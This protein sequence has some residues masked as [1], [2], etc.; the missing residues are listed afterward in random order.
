MLNMAEHSTSGSCGKMSLVSNGGSGRSRMSGTTN[1]LYYAV[2]SSLKQ[3]TS[4]QAKEF[5]KGRE[6]LALHKPCINLGLGIGKE[7]TN[8]QDQ[9]KKLCK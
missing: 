3:V 6:R 1:I 7:S 2:C 8:A 9:A 5:W 4:V